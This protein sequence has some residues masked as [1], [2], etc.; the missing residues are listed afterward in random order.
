MFRPKAAGHIFKL[1]EAFPGQ[2]IFGRSDAMKVLD[3]KPS[4]TS[5]LLKEMAE[6]GITEPVSEHGK[7]KYRFRIDLCTGILI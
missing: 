2:A 7:G 5:E 1:I 3:I 4:R 6:H